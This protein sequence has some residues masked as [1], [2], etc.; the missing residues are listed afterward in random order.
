MQDPGSGREL[1][2]DCLGSPAVQWVLAVH[3]FH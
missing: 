3:T 1:L 2:Q